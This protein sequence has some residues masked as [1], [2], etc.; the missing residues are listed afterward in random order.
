M[1]NFVVEPAISNQTLTF[2]IGLKSKPS[3]PYIEYGYKDR[4]LM[5]ATYS[6]HDV[7]LRKQVCRCPRDVSVVISE[8]DRKAGRTGVPVTLTFTPTDLGQ[9][10][11]GG[12]ITLKYPEAFF[13]PSVTPFAAVGASNIRDL[14]ATCSATAATFVVITTYGAAIPASSAFTMTLSGFTMSPLFLAGSF[15]VQ[16][17]SD[18]T[19]STGVSTGGTTVLHNG[20]AYKT[21]GNHNPHSETAV[22]EQYK[23]Y[24][25]DSGW[26]ISP[27]TPETLNM[28]TYPWAAYA[29]VF[30]DGSAHLTSLKSCGKQGEFLYPS[31]GLA[32]TGNNTYGIQRSCYEAGAPYADRCILGD[33]KGRSYGCTPGNWACNLP[34]C[35]WPSES[36]DASYTSQCYCWYF[37]VLIRRK[38]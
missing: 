28:C 26:E 16:T 6:F 17:S 7:M 14:G 18:S 23:R 12:T 33:A 11:S 19:A 10:P 36:N 30:S 2:T 20:Y 22:S 29:L 13:L 27:K 4:T 3:S 8:S 25:L 9:I 32:H 21:L 34:H 24:E 31:G 35:A 37:D 38:L 15:T 1:V 5:R